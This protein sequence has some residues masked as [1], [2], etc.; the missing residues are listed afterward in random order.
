MKKTV[1]HG[2]QDPSIPPLEDKTIHELNH[3]AAQ[4]FAKRSIPGSFII[5]IALLIIAYSSS[6]FSDAPSLI[7]L[8]ITVLVI[9]VVSRFFIL[10]ALPRCQTAHSLILW[11]NTFSL[12]VLATAMGWGCFVAIN[13]Y[14]YGTNALTMV[15]LMFTIGI[16]GGSAISLFIWKDLART[17]LSL[18]FLPACIVTLMNW[19]TVNA[20]IFFGFSVY[21]I[22]LFLQI[23]RS[24]NEYWLALCNTTLLEN[25]AIELANA[26]DYAEKANQA[27]SEFI[28]SMSHELRTPLNTVIGFSQ[29]IANNTKEPPT[30]SQAEYLGYIQQG[31]EHLLTLINQVLDLAVIE[32]GKLQLNIGSVSLAKVINECM[33]LIETQAKQQGITLQISKDIDYYVKADYMHLKQVLIN[34]LG[35]GVKYNRSGGSLSLSCELRPTTIRV[36]ITDTGIGI[37]AEE[38][39]HILTSFSH[40]N[41][42]NI[43][44]EGTGV[45]LSISK[46]IITSMF[47]DLGFSSVEGQGSTFWFEL[48]L[49]Q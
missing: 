47:G 26:K 16:A 4:D 45:G 48:P 15:V 38:Q 29:L 24:N 37:P 35:N 28:S 22:F 8:L 34:L 33:P 19:N 18:L 27:K 41:Q 42:A 13:L 46:N 39:E 9:S 21:Y 10:R 44:I 12:A 6:I 2:Y 49:Q 31:G 5:L 1:L 20:S 11:K 17:Y 7:Y 3:H 32:S 25:Q 14:F 40:F 43:S 23:I 36:N 30:P